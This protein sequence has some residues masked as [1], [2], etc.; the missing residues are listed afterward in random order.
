[1]VEDAERQARMALSCVVEGG[2]LDLVGLLSRYTPEEVWHSLRTGTADTTWILRARALR[3]SG[4]D[5]LARRH[6]VRFIVPGDDEWPTGVDDLTGAEPVQ[7]SG[8]APVGL[9][10][11]G[12][13]PL[14]R[15][16]GGAVAV[17]GSRASTAYGDRV[18]AELAGSLVPAGRTVIS[19]GAY[20]I[21][22]A[23]HR[24][25]L[26]E[27]GP[28][29][30]VL[31]GGLDEV[32]PKAHAGLFAAVAEGGALV[33]E[34]PPGE[35]PTRRRFLTRNR[36]IAALGV[37]T[38]VVEASVRSGARNTVSWATSMNRL[39]MAVPGPVSNPTSWTPH[40]LIRD[41]QASL[42]TGIDD[43]AELLSPL[44]ESWVDRPEAAR[45]LDLLSEVERRVYEALPARGSRDAG[46]VALRAGVGVREAL[47]ALADLSDRGLARPGDQGWRLGPRQDAPV[48]EGSGPSRRAARSADEQARRGDR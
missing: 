36:L 24:G 12:T 33:S 41:Q 37:G 42:V 39:V 19:G 18:A 8:G 10:V 11:R 1:M 35:H 22:A 7:K 40:R 16:V 29:V 6:G 47:T 9:W 4:V 43:V 46:D 21:D 28:T 45:V 48:P 14:G 13:H 23:A 3:L 26:A 32:Y 20:G 2:D 38:V 17:V 25:A 30:A 27:D 44:G 31:A 34:V 15:L 5:A